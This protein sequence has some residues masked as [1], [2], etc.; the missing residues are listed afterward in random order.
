M[1]PKRLVPKGLLADEL[2]P[3]MYGFGDEKLPVR[4]TVNAIEDAVVNYMVNMTKLAQLTAPRKAGI[5][6]GNILLH[7][8]KDKKKYQRVK[9]LLLTQQEIKEAKESFKK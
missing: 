8:R 4:E 9:D 3:M 5:K 1:P 7:C 6:F 2:V